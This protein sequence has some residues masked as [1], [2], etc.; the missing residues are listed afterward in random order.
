M[1]TA[2]TPMPRT[3]VQDACRAALQASGLPTRAS[4]HTVR[5]SA[6]TPLLAAGVTLRLSQASVGHPAP[7]TPAL[8][9]PL[10][11]TAD[12]LARE[13]LHRLLGDLS[14]PGRAALLACADRVRRHGP[15]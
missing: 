4:V 5:Q 14:P 2:S 15:A 10:T 12:A 13:A 7:T 9:T 6:A 1:S 11:R 8:S 3:S